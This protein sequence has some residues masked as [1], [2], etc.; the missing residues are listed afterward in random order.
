MPLKKAPGHDGVLTEKRVAA[1]EYVLEELTR[2]TNMVYN[3]G[4]FPEELN[5]Y[6]LITFP[7]IS[8]TTKCEKHRTI[9]LMSH[10]TKLIQRVVMNRVR[11]RTLQEISP[12]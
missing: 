3:H 11:G 6:T 12:E 4:Y 2:L 9:S 7:K 10:I 5:K 8:G 1:G